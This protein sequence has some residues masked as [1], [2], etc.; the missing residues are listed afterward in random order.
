[1]KQELE[2]VLFCSSCGGHLLQL[3]S[4]FKEFNVAKCYFISELAKDSEE[5]CSRYRFRRSILIKRVGSSSRALWLLKNF[6]SNF[7]KYLNICMRTDL[8]LSTGGIASVLPGLICFVLRRKIIFVETIAKTQDL[9]FTAKIFYYISNQFFVQDKN[10]SNKYK[11]AVF[12][13]TIYKI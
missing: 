2:N 8:M 13:G 10:L 4:V 12:L 1:M 5:V 3:Q 9:T 11:K 6:L 7:Q